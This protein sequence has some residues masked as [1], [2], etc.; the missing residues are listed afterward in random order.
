MFTARTLVLCLSVF[1]SIAFRLEDSEISSEQYRRVIVVSDMHGDFQALVQSLY[2]GY[3]D[4]IG[5]SAVSPREFAD[6]FVEALRSP[7]IP[8]KPLYTGNDVALIQ[9]GDLVD[10]GKY[11]RICIAL[12]KV[13]Q[14]VTGFKAITIM[15]NHELI[16]LLRVD[17]YD[18]LVHPEDDL[19]RNPTHFARPHGFMW[20]HMTSEMI[21]MVRWGPP[22]RSLVSSSPADPSSTSTLFV[23]GGITEEFLYRFNIVPKPTDY[24]TPYHP[25]EPR[26]MHHTP[27]SNGSVPISTNSFNRMIHEDLQ[28]RPF[29]ELTCKYTYDW[30]PFTSRSYGEPDVD[31]S[32]I[33][34][35]LALFDVSRIVV[36][37]SPSVVRRV[38]TNCDGKIIL[39]DIGASRYMI[40][41]NSSSPWFPGIVMF[42]ATS[43][44]VLESVS[45]QYLHAGDLRIFTE[46]IWDQQ[47][48]SIQSLNKWARDH[49]QAMTCIPPAF[50]GT[51]RSSFYDEEKPP[52]AKV[53]DIK[54]LE[55][56]RPRVMSI[57]TDKDS[58]AASAASPP[59]SSPSTPSPPRPVE[60]NETVFQDGHGKIQKAVVD[61]V[62]GFIVNFFSEDSF[63]VTEYLREEILSDQS[64]GRNFPSIHD[65]P[66]NQIMARTRSNP[67]R[68]NPFKY[69]KFLG[70]D[71][72]VLLSCYEEDLTS[73]VVDQMHIVMDTLH[74]GNVCLGL[75][76]VTPL[77]QAA[78]MS[79]FV[80]NPDTETVELVN[81][82]RLHRCWSE[83]EL[84]IERNL[85]AQHFVEFIDSDDDE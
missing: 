3:K 41:P 74:T 58:L 17:L 79:F 40:G 48:H 57:A 55:R 46:S 72:T 27:L 75:S 36:G 6:R 66:D 9:M 47:G 10:T 85:F 2:L 51:P 33:D 23:H 63:E 22:L 25:F 44:T 56:K 84:K 4:V 81:M 45:A 59:G 8:V 43:S 65:L 68:M 15:G 42:N 31:C 54:P 32:S 73:R 60:I 14:A 21:P 50:D 62:D 76:T 61:G 53:E 13:A 34:R 80:I 77:T 35:L 82:S 37:H 16:A 20:S 78:I 18:Q 71:A 39:S 26:L 7:S 83:Y 5:T 52:A 38:R 12:M 24:T 1:L 29:H 69:R 19:V 11:S 67:V 30:S 64:S 70:T 49:R 28:G